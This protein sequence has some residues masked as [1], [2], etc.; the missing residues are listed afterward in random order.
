MNKLEMGLILQLL[1][2]PAFVAAILILTISPADGFSPA[3]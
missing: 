3:V 2:P 1:Q